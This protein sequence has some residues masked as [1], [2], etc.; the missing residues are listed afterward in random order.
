M[1]SKF[2]HT[3]NSDTDYKKVT[4]NITSRMCEDNNCNYTWSASGD[5]YSGESV[6]YNQPNKSE[7]TFYNSNITNN[8]S[9]WDVWCN[10]EPDYRIEIELVKYGYQ[11]NYGD[12]GIG[13]I[14]DAIAN[15]IN[16]YVDQFNSIA[17]QIAEEVNIRLGQ[18][19]ALANNLVSN[20]INDIAKAMQ[21][22]EGAKKEIEDAKKLFNTLDIDTLEKLDRTNEDIRKLQGDLEWA[23]QELENAQGDGGI[24]NMTIDELAGMIVETA[25]Y[26]SKTEGYISDVRR[27]INAQIGGFVDSAQTIDVVR[28]SKTIYEHIVN[29]VNGTIETQLKDVT[30]SG[31]TNLSNFWDVIRGEIREGAERVS[32]DIV[33]NID[34]IKNAD[35]WATLS[36]KVVDLSSSAVTQAVSTLDARIGAIENI[37]TKVDPNDGTVTTLSDRL[38]ATDGTIT[39]YGKYIDTVSGNVNSVAAQLDAINSRITQSAQTI[40]TELSAVTSAVSIIDGKLGTLTNEVKTIQ[41]GTE[42]VVTQFLNSAEGQALLSGAVIDTTSSAVTAATQGFDAR[43]GILEQGIFSANTALSSITSLNQKFDLATNTISTT[44]AQMQ[45]GI[46]TNFSDI[47]Q[48]LSGIS[49]I[50]ESVSGDQKTTAGILTQIVDTPDGKEGN[51]TIKADKIVLAGNT[52][53]SAISATT[54]SLGQNKSKFFSD[55]SGYVGNSGITWTKDGKMTIAENVEIKSNLS[56]DNITIKEKDTSTVLGGVNQSGYA[57]FS[58]GK[59]GEEASF[60]VDYDGNIKCKSGIFGGSATPYVKKIKLFKD[61]SNKPSEITINQDKLTQTLESIV[62]DCFDIVGIPNVS[63][64]ESGEFSESDAADGDD[65]VGRIRD[66]GYINYVLNLDKSGVNVF[67]DCEAIT[68]SDRN[69]N[70][71]IN[72]ASGDE[73]ARVESSAAPIFIDLPAYEF[74]YGYN[75][76]VDTSFL[77]RGLGMK[78][79]IDEIE[80]NKKLRGAYMNYANS[81]I[82][83]KFILTL[84]NGSLSRI[85]L[86]GVVYCN[87]YDNEGRNI[88]IEQIGSY[89]DI[90]PLSTTYFYTPGKQKAYVDDNGVTYV[91]NTLSKPNQP[92]GNTVTFE[93][94]AED[95]FIDS[96]PISRVYWRAVRVNSNAEYNLSTYPDLSQDPSNTTRYD[97]GYGV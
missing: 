2:K 38:D 11:P 52:I 22:I 94:V 83:Q 25:V 40:N 35:G 53:A 59:N 70:I 73:I 37:V 45:S 86:R 33:S 80:E 74:G 87:E 28:G 50:V 16:K 26:T 17:D 1:I 39:Q 30:S 81:F 51:V 19:L 6:I 88:D 91:T 65:Y 4:I 10:E 89:N 8:I 3:F 48:S 12:N 79:E 64:L 9:V 69:S 7:I 5:G 32:G 63:G 95:S 82:G 85:Y 47:R 29:T 20:A 84:K 76:G 36:G 23:R 58:G 67:I 14:D 43:L 68:T 66:D 97:K 93:C 42:G 55:G 13:G 18:E 96:S 44:V 78:G 41:N 21:D 49:L 15:E 57:F 72:D 77:A 90:I 71:Y 56:V 92:N 34:E 31:V 62:D 54:I 75:H 27:E 61:W 46:T 24:A 60:A